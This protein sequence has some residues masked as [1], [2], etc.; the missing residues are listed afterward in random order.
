V[1]KYGRARQAKD[2]DIMQ[3]RKYTIC[4]ANCDVPFGL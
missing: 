3:H 4:M 1:E 2:D